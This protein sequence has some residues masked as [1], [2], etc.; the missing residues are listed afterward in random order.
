MQPGEVAR[1]LGS[2]EKL[3]NQLFADLCRAE[4]N[5]ALKAIQSEVDAATGTEAIKGPQATGP[6]SAFA[7]RKQSYYTRGVGKLASMLE[8]DARKAADTAREA[9]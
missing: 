2:D 6:T 9:A 1:A 8:E 5:D 3:R 4:W 7:K